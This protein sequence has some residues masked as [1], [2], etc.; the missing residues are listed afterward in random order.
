NH[1]HAQR[2]LP[3]GRGAAERQRG[4]AASAEGVLRQLPEP[5]EHEGRAAF[6]TARGP[7]C[8]ARRMGRRRCECP[9]QRLRVCEPDGELDLA[10]WTGAAGRDLR[11]AMARDP[12]RESPSPSAKQ[13]K[14]G[15]CICV[16]V[17]VCAG[18]RWRRCLLCLWW[19]AWG[20]C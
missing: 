5:A 12:A 19:C 16:T 18:R 3:H 4:G 6:D 10:R 14:Y 20:C 9:R 2:W 17:P 11:L 13:G 15:S 1:Y 7:V 8:G